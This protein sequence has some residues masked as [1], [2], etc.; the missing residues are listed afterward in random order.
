MCVCV[1][2]EFY[3]ILNVAVGGTSGWFPDWAGDKPWLDGSQSEHS[4][5]PPPSKGVFFSLTRACARPHEGF[6]EK[7]GPVVP[8]LADGR[9]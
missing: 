8:H 1:W 5:P 4:P 9:R 2:V 3:L 6:C 7:P